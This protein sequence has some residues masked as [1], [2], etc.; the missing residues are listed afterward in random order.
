MILKD[1]F[2]FNF[3]TSPEVIGPILSQLFLVGENHELWHKDSLEGG[4]FK[5]IRSHVKNDVRT[6]SGGNFVFVH[7]FACKDENVKFFRFTVRVTPIGRTRE[8][9]KNDIPGF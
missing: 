1:A 2:L 7:M 8:D 4:E 9:E 3:D 5:L 6:I